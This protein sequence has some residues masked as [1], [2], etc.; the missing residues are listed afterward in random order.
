MNKKKTF[1]MIGLLSLMIP[2]SLFLYF[3]LNMHGEDS[4]G[5][6]LFS[7]FVLAPM[8]IIGIILLILSVERRE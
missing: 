6:A 2:I 8:F 4:V 1:S 3:F 5:Y 7:I